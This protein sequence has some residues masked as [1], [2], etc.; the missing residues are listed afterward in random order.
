MTRLTRISLAIGAI[1]ALGV[2]LAASAHGGKQLKDNDRDR[3]M[4][5]TDTRGNLLAFKADSPRRVRF[6]AITGLPA[7]SR[8]E[9]STSGRRRAIS[10]PSGATRSSTA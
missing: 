8:S 3:V 9:A 4:F 10:T 6:T 5:A 7:A 2:P 1:L